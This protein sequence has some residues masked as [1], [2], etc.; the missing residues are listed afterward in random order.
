VRLGASDFDYT[1]VVSGLEEG[2][3]V[4][5]LAV[6]AMQAQRDERNEQMRSRMG[7]PLPGVGGGGAPRG[8]APAGGGG[9]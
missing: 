6:A 1:E 9:R 5:L 7:G 8:G 2:E 3:S 4:A